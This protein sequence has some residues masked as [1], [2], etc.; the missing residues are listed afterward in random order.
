MKPLGSCLN[1]RYMASAG[2]VAVERVD[3][4]ILHHTDDLE[5]LAGQED[6][7][8]PRAEGIPVRPVGVAMD[9]LIRMAVGRPG[10][11]VSARSRPDESPIQ[12][13][14]ESR[15]G[16]HAEDVGAGETGTAGRPSM[17]IGQWPVSPSSGM[18]ADRLADS[19]PGS[20]R[21]RSRT[22]S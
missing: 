19:T 6:A 15:C 3:L 22:R 11:S 7:G 10:M 9:W 1:D 21:A 14:Q 16:N 20:A 18:L 12:R 8:Q 5:C 2:D 4:R 13:L 17:A